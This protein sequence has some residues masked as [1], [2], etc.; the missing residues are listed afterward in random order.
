MTAKFPKITLKAFK[1][2]VIGVGGFFVIQ[3]ATSRYLSNPALGAEQRYT[4]ASSKYRE[5]KETIDRFYV[6]GDLAKESFHTGRF[7]EAR[8]YADEL[9]QITPSHRDNWNYG[10]AIQDANIVHGLLALRSGDRE[11]AKKYL[12][13]AGDSP[14]SPQMNSFGPNMCLAKALL[15][16]G[17]REAVLAYFEQCRRF[18][19]S[20]HHKLDQWK[21]IASK[22]ITPNFGANLVF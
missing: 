10:N 2:I 20:K 8:K 6:L 9:D 22:G 18:W 7:D 16:A 21:F 19:S 12:T 13:A 17:E 15:E 5:A 4:E 14:G 3:F 1:P 11:S